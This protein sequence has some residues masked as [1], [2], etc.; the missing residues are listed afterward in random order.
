MTKTS[1]YNVAVGMIVALGSF[2]YGFGFATFATSIGQP[3]FY[4]YFNLDPTTPYT[5]SI[6]GAVNALFF[7]GACVGALGAGPLSDHIGRRWTILA[8]ALVA[9]IGGALAAGSVRNPIG[10]ILGAC[11]LETAE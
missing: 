2:S 9:L 6:L 8:A 4:T 7:F 3:G 10:A 5:N 11:H 1:N